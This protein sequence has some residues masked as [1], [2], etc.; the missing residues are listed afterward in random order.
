VTDILFFIV[1]V[2]P[3]NSATFARWRSQTVKFAW[4]E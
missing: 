2:E 1:L 4:S 3:Q